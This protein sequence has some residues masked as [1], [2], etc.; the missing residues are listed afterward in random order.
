M[1]RTQRFTLAATGLGLFMIFLDALIVNVALPSIQDDFHVG[2]SGLQWVV[3][4][5]S[6]GMAVAIM[7]A[8]T[9][10]DLHGRRKLYLAG[11]ALFT[12]A[13][14]ACGLARS[15]DVLNAAR[16]VQGVAAA[17]VNV[18][19]LALVSAAF[20]DP[21]QKAWAIGIWTAIASTAM[22]I[23]PT[24]GG[25]L[26]QRAGW[27]IIFLVN[28]PVGIAVLA[29]TSRF[30]AESRDERPRRF[31]V[32]GQL[33]FVA[34]VGAFAY[35]VIEGPR[36][37]WTSPEIL[38]LFGLA[39]AALAAFVAVER[40]SRDPMMDLTLFRDRTYA[41]A[42]VT[43]F[44]VLFAVYGMLLVITQ[45]LQNVRGF[46]PTQAGLLL[47]PYS[48]TCTLVSLRAGKMM[49][50]V[51]S[52]RLILAG[53]FSQIVGFGILIAGMGH[54]TPV[55]VI[56]MVF[57][58]LGSALCLTP[59]TS[60][61]MTAVP[62]ERAG[63]ASG[64]MSAQ[65]ALGSTVGFAVLGS[66]L[67]ASLTATLSA[68]LAAALPD[69]VERKEVAATII[70]NANPR[71]YAAEIG[72]GRPIGHLDEATRRAILAAADRDF[73]EGIRW[74]LGVAIV[75]LGAVFAAGLAGFPRGR[76]GMADATR[77]AGK[78]E[79]EEASRSPEG[80]FS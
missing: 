61:A 64:I 69:P 68:H 11:I 19:S 8:A 73:V 44:T 41:L 50:I 26:V 52:R 77:E 21:R 14:V 37:G 40:S 20:A 38:G 66:V 72:P 13:S 36:A 75:V 30:V 67:A 27:R 56:G 7:S 48:A 3:T 65:R 74:S 80:A 28:V 60:L 23:G 39:V 5:Y 57:S 31:D 29:L 10:A 51:G 79:A 78:L 24:L 42:I 55:V 47:L 17:T 76:G 25:F 35:A 53:L 49:G 54:A 9:L 16:A 62:P 18:T 22:A 34:A 4:A 45:Y 6:L 59:I 2:E 46:S 70:G 63:M 12:A 33:L 58:S 1:D 43:I 32:P 15:L 71:A